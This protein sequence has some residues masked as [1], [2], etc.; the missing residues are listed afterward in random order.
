MIFDNPQQI[1][2]PQ[3]GA[4][5]TSP[6]GPSPLVI[7]EKAVVVPLAGGRLA[8][9]D[10]KSYALEAVLHTGVDAAIRAT[11]AY[12]E[13]AGRTVVYAAL[14]RD[15]SNP[16]THEHDLLFAWWL[17]TGSVVSGWP[18]IMQRNFAGEGGSYKRLTC[19]DIDGDG[20]YEVIVTSFSHFVEVVRHTGELLWRYNADDTIVSGAVVGDVNGDGRMEVV[21]G[22]DTSDNPWFRGGGLLNILNDAG[23]A[24]YRYRIEEVVWSTPKLVDLTGNG[25]PD[26]VFGTGLNHDDFEKRPKARAAGNRIYAIDGRGRPIPGWP[27]H[28]TLNDNHKHQVIGDIQAFESVSHGTLVTAI[29]R[30]GLLH[31]VHPDGRPHYAFDGGKPLHHFGP[32][33]DGYSTPLKVDYQ[34]QE[35]IVGSNGPTLSAYNLSGD[36]QGIYAVHGNPPD[37]HFSKP[38]QNGEDLISLSHISLSPNRPKTLSIFSGFSKAPKDD[39]TPVPHPARPDLT[40]SLLIRVDKLS[41][42]AY[43]H[44]KSR[45]LDIFP[46]D[47]PRAILKARVRACDGDYKQASTIC[48]WLRCLYRDVLGRNAADEELLL[49]YDALGEGWL[50]I[51]YIPMWL[52]ASPEGSQRI[53]EM[54]YEEVPSDYEAQTVDIL[55][56][57]LQDESMGV[58]RTANGNPI[59]GPAVNPHPGML[60]YFTQQRRQG[61]TV[62]RLIVELLS[63]PQYVR[64]ASFY[65]GIWVGVGMRT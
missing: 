64:A 23:S 5:P 1:P 63:S 59:H 52:C 35:F 7:P 36:R 42:V 21:F 28:T 37:S 54:G 55:M 14:G 18:F 46:Q 4:W 51:D 60:A 24:L 65:K 41:E 3:D 31:V 26:I 50:A 6:F 25:I 15:E 13:V 49:W 10:P 40:G 19:A 38:V 33:Q 34:G 61:W 12:A 9:L 45:W 48:C 47:Y 57:F 62:M 17:D 53:S 2:L 29:D 16:G 58:L 32:V 30:Q 44:D 11:P 8:V 20:F 22:S 56:R 39:H 43:V 27:Y